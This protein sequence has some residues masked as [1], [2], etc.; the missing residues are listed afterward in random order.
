MKRILPVIIC[1]LMLFCSNLQAEV[2]RTAAGAGYKK[3]VE[4]WATL[5]QDQS[6]K[7]VERIYGNMGQVTAQVKQG[8]GI[9]IVV[10]DKSYLASHGLPIGSYIT[11]GQGRPVLVTRKG[12]TL[13]SLAEL[14]QADF[15]RI[16]APDFSKAIY[17]RAAQQILSQP[18]YHQVLAKVMAVG[19]VPR[20]GAYALSGEVDAAFVNMSFALANR[21]KFGSLLELTSGFEPIEIVAGI[22]TG[23]EKKA[24]VGIFTSL[25][26]SEAMQANKLAAGL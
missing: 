1:I 18:T 8:G 4:R 14:K 16:A 7:K 11:I 25:L 13:T 6:G 10:G 22:I 2:L 15:A 21:N 17:G 19:T 12:L 5:Y 3:F 24:E 20:S 23:C 9:C 26:Q